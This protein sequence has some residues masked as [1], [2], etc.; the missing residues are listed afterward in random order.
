MVEETH[1]W[2]AQC[3]KDLIEF[4]KRPENVI[5]EDFGEDDA[6]W[7]Q[8]SKQDAERQRRQDE[9]MRQRVKARSKD[10]RG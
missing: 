9:F 10:E 3:R 6:K 7:E 2:C 1:F 4:N 8:Q 5:P